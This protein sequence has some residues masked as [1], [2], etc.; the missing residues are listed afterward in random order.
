MKRLSALVFLAGLF[1]PAVGHS[2]QT[3][4]YD[5]F[6]GVGG[7]WARGESR[8]P[9]RE[10]FDTMD[11]PTNS[12]PLDELEY[13]A[14]DLVGSFGVY[15]I[16]PM[17]KLPAGQPAQRMCT[18]DFLVGEFLTAPGSGQV[19]SCKLTKPPRPVIKVQYSFADA[20]F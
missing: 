19:I 4:T 13:C 17:I 8:T 12:Y 9:L 18:F 16:P 11:I 3:I 10:E 14:I 1:L 2:E 15:H 20:C 6:S 5:P 7:S